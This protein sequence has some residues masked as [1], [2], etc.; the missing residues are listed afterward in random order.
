MWA[1]PMT[2]NVGWLHTTL[3]VLAQLEHVDRLN[4][5]LP[6]VSKQQHKRKL[7]SYIGKVAQEDAS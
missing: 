4:Y 3:D 5:F 1:I 7:G 2:L 6:R